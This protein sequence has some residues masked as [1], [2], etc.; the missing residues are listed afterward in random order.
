MKLHFESDYLEGAHPKI[1]ERLMKTNMEKTVGYG[2]DEYSNRA[3]EKIRL[4][5]GCPEAEVYF[6]TGGTQANATIIDGL[7]KSY[8]GVVAADSGH[9]N[10][11]EAGAIEHSGH[12]V[13]A[14]PNEEGKLSAQSL[15]SYLTDYHQDA[16][17]EHMVYPGM[18]YISFPTEYGTL[19]L[20]RELTDIYQVCKDY[21]IPLFVDGAR[22][23]YGLMAPGNDLTL[24]QLAQLCD[25]F[26]IGGTKVGALF[27][28]AVVIPNSKLIP[29]FF[30]II[31]QHG[32]LLAKG[33]IL[34]LQF[35]TLF[36]DNLYFDI[37]AHAIKMADKMKQ[38]LTEKGYSFFI[39]SPTNQ[40]FVI[41]PNEQMQ[42]ISEKVSFSFWQKA[43]EESTVIRLATS[44][45]TRKEDVEK[46]KEIL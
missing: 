29:H 45:A 44:W 24:P 30:T 13:L 40:V 9:I 38:I 34:G 16:N 37:S 27:G 15:E 46:L 8:E 25:V 3:K 31:K 17:N 1:L 11:H 36:T 23:G 4:A 5:C 33:R 21:R 12:K 39:N 2:R 28:E 18:V 10:L 19:Y 14:I 42:K 6:L 22:L 32:A 20:V 26:Y 41:L 7:L 35:D 43:S